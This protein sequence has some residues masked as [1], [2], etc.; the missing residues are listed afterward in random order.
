MCTVLGG[1]ALSYHHEV[2][3]HFR[4]VSEMRNGILT[5]FPSPYLVKAWE[6]AYTVKDQL[7]LSLERKTNQPSFHIIIKKWQNNSIS[8]KLIY[9]SC[10]C[11]PSVGKSQEGG[12]W[13]WLLI[14]PA[15]CLRQTCTPERAWSFTFQVPRTHCGY[16]WSLLPARLTH[17]HRKW[18]R[19][20]SLREQSR[21]FRKMCW[22]KI[23]RMFFF[24]RAP[25]SLCQVTA[26]CNSKQNL[27]LFTAPKTKAC[28]R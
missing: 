22:S 17:F 27:F 4:H 25:K 19:I 11:H 5:G 15:A 18:R 21:F 8:G 23:P 24:W 13:V 3:Q 1:Q 16:K 28:K 12:A 10:K 26:G 7:M 2:Y 9:L 6:T 14:N 20:M